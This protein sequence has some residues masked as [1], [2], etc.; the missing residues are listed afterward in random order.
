MKVSS[1]VGDFPFTLT[2]VRLDRGRLVV[3]GQMGRWPASIVI[4]HHD[5][6]PLRRFGPV[7]IAAAALTVGL[8]ARRR[9]P[10]SRRALHRA[11]PRN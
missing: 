10:K 2:G 6:K 5:L 3:E 1:P 8:A 4:D 7:A 9:S 11:R